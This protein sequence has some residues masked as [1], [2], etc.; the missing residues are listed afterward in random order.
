MYGGCA[1][2]KEIREARRGSLAGRRC[3]GRAVR[4]TGRHRRRAGDSGGVL[5][6][7]MVDQRSQ[8]CELRRT[9]RF[10]CLVDEAVAPGLRRGRRGSIHIQNAGRKA[11]RSDIEGSIYRTCWHDVLIQR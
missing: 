7:F 9:C 5:D 10:A 3:R 1:V 4:C 11:V 6:V 8:K 2:G